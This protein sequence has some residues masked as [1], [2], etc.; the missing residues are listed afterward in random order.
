ME[1]WSSALAFGTTYV[2]ELE[3]ALRL[4]LAALFAAAIGFEREMRKESA[5]LRTHMLTALSAAM[6][7][8][9]TFE[10]FHHVRALDNAPSVDP[11][12][13]IEA[14]T[15]GVSFL[16]A[17]TI[18]NGR[19][20]V[21]G[22]TTGCGI[23]MAGAI[24]VACGTGFYAIALFGAVSGILIIVFL[25]RFERQVLNTKPNNDQDDKKENPFS[26]SER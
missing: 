3:I 2:P 17:G 11:V 10:I 18:I 5:G 1:R 12:R 20:R 4:L 9:L 8:I 16:A 6:F 22:L 21:Q 26:G 24:G 25:R 15:A 14:V 7:T 19:D 13:L 23:W